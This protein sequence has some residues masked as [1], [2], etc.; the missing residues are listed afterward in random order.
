MWKCFVEFNPEMH[1]IQA[2]DAPY[3]VSTTLLARLEKASYLIMSNESY[4]RQLTKSS[5]FFIASNN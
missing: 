4:E 2:E 5:S 3:E 1:R